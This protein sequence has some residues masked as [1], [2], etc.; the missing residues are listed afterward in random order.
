M[1]TQ[2][3]ALPDPVAAYNHLFNNVHSQVFFGKL[4]SRGYAPQNE[5]QAQDLLVLAGKLRRVA[6]VSEK[7]A[8]DHSPFA[9]ALNALDGYLG[10]TGMGGQ[11]AAQESQ[12]AIKEAAAQLANDPVVY[13]CVLSL[14]AQE[15]AL[16]AQQFQGQ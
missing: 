16:A 3:Q 4:A 10:E 13:N 15:A 5:K 11:Q 7:A 8:S 12:M 14:K 6:Q 9:G 1:S 2:Q